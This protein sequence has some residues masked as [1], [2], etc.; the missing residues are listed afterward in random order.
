MN[1]L[2]LAY[3]LTNDN[4]P[5][6]FLL[7]EISIKSISDNGAIETEYPCFYGLMKPTTFLNGSSEL[8]TDAEYSVGNSSVYYSASYE[9][10]MKFLVQKREEVFKKYR[11]MLEKANT[12]YEK[13]SNSEIKKN[14]K[15]ENSNGLKKYSLW[16]EGY[17]VTGNESTAQYLGEFE[18]NSFNDA[19]DNWAKTIENPELYKSGTSEHSPSHW[20]C[21]IFDNE[22]DARK[23]FG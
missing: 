15:S 12:I 7:K 4:E 8:K 23:S 5:F 19:C 6:Q 3:V 17:A 21:R 20:A 18:G 16:M 14:V 10:C 22:M 11:I 13:F 1:A 2:Y 9:D